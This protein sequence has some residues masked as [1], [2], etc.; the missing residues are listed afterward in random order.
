MGRAEVCAS[1]IYLVFLNRLSALPLPSTVLLDLVRVSFSILQGVWVLR[2]VARSVISTCM[3]TVY[4]RLTSRFVNIRF[5]SASYIG[6]VR[7]KK[8][9]EFC[10]EDTCKAF[11]AIRRVHSC[12]VSDCCLSRDECYFYHEFRIAWRFFVRVKT[13]HSDT[14][15][16]PGRH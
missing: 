6:C 1:H 16:F 12:E 3:K 10:K 8:D 2:Y 7:K 11:E 15:L 4:I 14:H 13:S 9:S 5:I